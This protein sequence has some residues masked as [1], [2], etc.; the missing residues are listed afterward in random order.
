VPD[1]EGGDIRVDVSAPFN[2]SPG[3]GM[4]I[5]SLKIHGSTIM[6]VIDGARKQLHVGP[7]TPAALTPTSASGPTGATG[8]GSA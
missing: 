2:G 4:G 5:S 3:K 7:G 6:R 1:G 8:T